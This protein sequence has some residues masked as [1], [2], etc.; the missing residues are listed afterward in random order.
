MKKTAGGGKGDLLGTVCHI[1]GI[2]DP[3]SLDPNS[4][5]SELGMDS[6]M[7]IEIKQGLERE[8]DMVLTTQEIRNM[9]VKDLREMGSDDRKERK[10]RR[11]EEGGRQ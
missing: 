7:A 8:Y 4:T 5:L 9:K 2:R 6:L 1:L 11:E 3:S 10:G